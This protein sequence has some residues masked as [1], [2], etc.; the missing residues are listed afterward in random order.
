MFVHPTQQLS[1]MVAQTSN[2][3]SEVDA[4]MSV[5]VSVSVSVAA[6]SLSERQQ[7]RAEWSRLESDNAELRAKLAAALR[8]L[9][10]DS[11]VAQDRPREENVSALL[12]RAS[13]FLSCSSSLLRHQLVASLAHIQHKHIE[14]NE[15]L[16]ND[17]KAHESEKKQDGH[18]SKQQQKEGDDVA[19]D[20]KKAETTGTKSSRAPRLTPSE[21]GELRFLLGPSPLQLNEDASNDLNV[22]SKPEHEP[23]LLHELFP[24]A[25]TRP[26]YCG[27]DHDF[28]LERL[29]EQWRSVYSC[30]GPKSQNEQDP[31]SA[32]TPPSPSTSPNAAA[33]V[34]GVWDA[35]QYNRALYE[36]W[37]TSNPSLYHHRRAASA[38]STPTSSLSSA[39]SSTDTELESDASVK[40]MDNWGF[41]VAAVEGSSWPSPSSSAGSNESLIEHAEH[42]HQHHQRQRSVVMLGEAPRKRE[43]TPTPSIPTPPS[44]STTESDYYPFDEPDQ[45]SNIV[46][47]TSSNNKFLVDDDDDEDNIMRAIKTA[48]LPKLIERLTHDKYVD[49]NMRHVFLLTFHKFTNS[50]ELLRLLTLRYNVP[51]PL[52]LTPEESS[53]FRCVKSDLIHVRV[54]SMI[55]NWIE[56]YWEED[57]VLDSDLRLQLHQFVE[58]MTREKVAGVRQM[59]RNLQALIAKKEQQTGTD[60]TTAEVVAPDVHHV[61]AP[62][63]TSKSAMSISRANSPPPPTSSPTPT[64]TSAVHFDFDRCDEIDIARQLTLLDWCSL[65]RISPRELVDKR[66]SRGHV[67][68]RQRNAP[69][70]LAFI[71]Q[72]NR[73]ATWVQCA[74]LSER[75]MKMRVKRMEKFVKIAEHCHS[76]NNFHSTFALYCGLTSNPLHRLHRT[77]GNLSSKSSRILKEL[78]AL[79]RT[80]SNSKTF[81]KV[82]RMASPPA[83]PHL[84][85]VLTD[86]TF[87]EDGNKDFIATG[88]TKEQRNKSS[89]ED[90]SAAQQQQHPQQQQQQVNWNKMSMIADRIRSAVEQFQQEGYT[91]FQPQA[92]IQHYISHTLEQMDR[93]STEQLWKLSKE[94]EPKATSQSK[95]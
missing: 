40:A 11:D 37:S 3:N 62:S 18:D 42:H 21:Q 36:K 89:Q 44:P 38:G 94:V 12:G 1:I 9:Y 34:E 28:P 58:K 82:M 56:E 15:L 8:N 65:R 86:L 88:G 39:R 90:G 55:K 54:A 2:M 64:P 45:A 68:E 77:R 33:S 91:A 93:F 32:I 60:V 72:F 71:R 25:T 79:F 74:V 53:R 49:L 95:S 46:F 6:R 67:E 76:L 27:L 92:H 66:W 20:K 52:A 85:L 50:R 26:P 73:V 75:E 5:S 17:E 70:T 63:P 10:P 13:L 48:T 14:Q 4:G 41:A 81:R 7:Q 59:A 35:L 87:I 24:R 47:D 30:I 22:G 78:G 51:S 43:S 83:V 69:N 29:S 84:G 19:T 16:T 31:S 23:S 80:E 57:F 61:S